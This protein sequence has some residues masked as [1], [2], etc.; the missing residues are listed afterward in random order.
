MIHLETPLKTQVEYLLLMNVCL[1]SYNLEIIKINLINQ[2]IKHCFSNLISQRESLELPLAQ[3]HRNSL[4]VCQ[5]SKREREREG[6]SEKQ[7]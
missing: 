1:I 7:S 2:H 6:G 4:N 3:D 5:M